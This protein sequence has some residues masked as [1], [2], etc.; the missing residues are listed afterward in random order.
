VPAVRVVEALDEVE[1][2]TPGLGLGAKPP[3]I[4]QL[5]LQGG[6]EALTERVVVPGGVVAWLG[7]EGRSP[8]RRE[9]ITPLGRYQASRDG[10]SC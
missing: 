1:D 5:A 2:G 3:P 6:E 10:S 7:T 8:V 9:R 4:E